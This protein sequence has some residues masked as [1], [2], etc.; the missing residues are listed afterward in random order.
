MNANNDSSVFQ[1]KAVVRTAFHL[2][3][4]LSKREFLHYVTTTKTHDSKGRPCVMIAYHSFLD[5]DS[6]VDIP[7][8]F[9]NHLRCPQFPSGQRATLLENGNVRVEHCMTYALVGNIRK[10]IQ[11]FVFHRGHV[12]AYYDG[13]VKAMERLS[14]VAEAAVPAVNTPNIRVAGEPMYKTIESYKE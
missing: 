4:P 11:N 2:P 1:Y 9:P 12:G 14:N 3:K 8:A 6:S 10:W 7:P 5:Q 13:W